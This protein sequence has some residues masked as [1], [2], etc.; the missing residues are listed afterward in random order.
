MD[1]VCLG[2]D[3]EVLV[4][5]CTRPLLLPLEEMEEG[6]RTLRLETLRGVVLYVLR[7]ELREVLRG[8]LLLLLRGVVVVVDDGCTPLGVVDVVVLVCSLVLSC[9]VD[10]ML[11]S[12]SME[13][14]LV[15]DVLLRSCLLLLLR[16]LLL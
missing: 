15:E 1:G 13:E 8:V 7:V 10:V 11:M 3:L 12:N 4:K 5:I 2:V 9:V 16:L 14:E 6:V